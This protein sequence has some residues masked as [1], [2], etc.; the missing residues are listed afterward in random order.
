MRFA[1]SER[2]LLMIGRRFR[3]CGLALGGALVVL[4]GCGKT[5]VGAGTG[6]ASA[7]GAA[8]SVSVVTAPAK[9][10]PMGIAIE[11]VGTT[12]ANESIQVTSKA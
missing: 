8:Q 10:E 2:R 7:A 12:R 5:E 1:D 9:R 11:A 6:G 3:A 4:G